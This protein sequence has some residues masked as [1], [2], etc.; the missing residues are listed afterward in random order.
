[1][2]QMRNEEGWYGS[3]METERHDIKDPAQGQ[4][5]ILRQLRFQ[6][7]PWQK[8][9]PKVK[10]ILTPD[11]I[12]YLENLLWADNLEMI[13]LPKVTFHKKGF[14]IFLTCKAKKGNIIPYINK[15][16]LD[17]PLHERLKEGQ[18]PQ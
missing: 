7:A 17:R 1:M 15:E 16:D 2:E 12:K 13:Q 3:T 5:V 9:K 18:E 4:P 11:Y 14:R 6:Y 8:T 10:D